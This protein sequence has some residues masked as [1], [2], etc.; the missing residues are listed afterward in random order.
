MHL[1]ILLTTL[2][3][4]NISNIKIQLHKEKEGGDERYTSLYQEDKELIVLIEKN[5]R[6]INVLKKLQSNLSIQDKFDIIE[7]NELSSTYKNMNM[8]AGGLMD[9][10]EFDIS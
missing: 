8:K 5:E 10:W 9:D 6:N 2:L 4:I 1:F 3:V 7:K